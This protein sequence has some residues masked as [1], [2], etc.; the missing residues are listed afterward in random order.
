MMGESIRIIIRVVL[1][2]G[3][4]GLRIYMMGAERQLET[5]LP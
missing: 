1:R 4:M 5:W 3:V 2:G